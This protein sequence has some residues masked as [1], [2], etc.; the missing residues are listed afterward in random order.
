MFESIAAWMVVALFALGVWLI[1]SAML[2]S[3]ARA[4]PTVTNKPPAM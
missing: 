2:G 1:V 3:P 4:K